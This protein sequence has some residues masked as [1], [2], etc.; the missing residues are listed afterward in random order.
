[1]KIWTYFFYLSIEF[2]LL[3]NFKQIYVD[4]FFFW[5]IFLIKMGI[6]T[7]WKNE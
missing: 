2:N 1:M 3:N 7:I 6:R 5:D 4:K